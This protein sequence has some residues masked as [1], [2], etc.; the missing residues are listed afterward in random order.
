MKDKPGLTIQR[1]L[2]DIKTQVKK[3][4]DTIRDLMDSFE[5]RNPSSNWSAPFQ[6]HRLRRALRI[7]Y[8]ALKIRDSTPQSPSMRNLS[9]DLHNDHDLP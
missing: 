1:D 5:Y 4:L 2:D 7:H 8:L 9:W 6:I 3:E